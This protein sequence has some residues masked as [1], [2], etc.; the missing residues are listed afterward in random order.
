MPKIQKSASS[1]KKTASP[2]VS[3]V[4][5]GK[6]PPMEY[7]EISLSIKASVNFQ[8]VGGHVCFKSTDAALLPASSSKTDIKEAIRK[9]FDALSDSIEPLHEN[10][11]AGLLQ[12][13]RYKD[14]IV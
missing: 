1:K 4:S 5:R 9:N 6:Q 8:S 2:S 14:E 10:I 13:N 12:V 11:R 3:P 7:I